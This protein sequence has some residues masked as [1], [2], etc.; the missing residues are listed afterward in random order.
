MNYR[1]IVYTI[2]L[3]VSTF[4]ISGINFTGIFKTNHE[5]EAKIFVALVILG[6]SYISS[7]FII[8]FIDLF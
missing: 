2:M 3:F 5:I 8:N 7:Q 1:I 6:L 4:A